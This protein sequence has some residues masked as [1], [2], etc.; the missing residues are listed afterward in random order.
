MN[1]S[2]LFL[3]F[4]ALIAFA[5]SYDAFS[6]RITNA[7]CLSIAA[8]FVPAAII[9]GLPF[10]T[11]LLHLSCA[12]AMLGAGFVLFARGWI[13][14]GDAKLFAAAALWFGWSH[15]ADFAATVAIA[16]GLLALGVIALRS[17]SGR[18]L[19]SSEWIRA[20]LPYGIAIACGTLAVYPHTLWAAAF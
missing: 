14:G 19:A 4:P 7:L 13:G 10:E 20:E 3:I 18:F 2:I 6:L 11:M 15:I 1:S 12:L 5:A 9:A 8:A 17:I 16:G